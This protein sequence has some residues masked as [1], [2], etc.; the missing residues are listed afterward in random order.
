M[1]QLLVGL[2]LLSLGIKIIGAAFSSLFALLRLAMWTLLLL[3]L[4]G[5]FN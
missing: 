3:Y 1:I 5:Y 4:C 2:V